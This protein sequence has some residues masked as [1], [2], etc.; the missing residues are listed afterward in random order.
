MTFRSLINAG[1]VAALWAPPVLLALEVRGNV[2]G[3]YRHFFQD[4]V[5]ERQHDGNGSFSAEVEI[6]NEWDD[7][8]QMFAFTPFLRVDQQDDERTHADIRELTWLYIAR[9]W[10]LRV[11]I[12]KLFWGVTESQHL[13][14]IINQ[15][16]LV[17]NVDGEDKLGQ[18]MINLAL[19]QNWGALDLFVM[20]YFRERTFP[21]VDGRLRTELPVDTDQAR[22]ESSDEER[23]VDYALRWDHNISV[24]DFGLSHFYGNSREPRLLLGQDEGKPVLIPFYDV[25]HQTGLDVQAT[26]GSWLWKFEG[27]HRIGQAETFNA[28]TAGFEYTFFGI[29]AT[30]QD[31][32]VLVEYLHDDRGEEAPTPFEDDTLLGMRWVL[33]DEQSTEALFGVV[34]DNSGEGMALN[35]EA[36]RRFGAHWKLNLE[37]RGYADTDAGDPLHGLRNDDYAQVE[38]FYFF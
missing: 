16:D 26:I 29:F 5:D 4:P 23:H 14:D 38:L 9:D 36:S 19:I 17:E 24:W 20:P 27:I 35:L 7:R 15:T 2:A 22:Y 28:V 30:P 6:F 31:L 3:E 34:V 25:I 37:A 12:R 21:G 10:E 18:P 32:G 8:R 13:V 11:G 1:V 33:N